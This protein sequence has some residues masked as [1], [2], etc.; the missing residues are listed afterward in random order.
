MLELKTLKLICHNP[1]YS[2][3]ELLRILD[4]PNS[5]MTNVINR[6]TSKGLLQRKLSNKDLR[7]FELELTEKGKEAVE[8]H[9]EAETGI[10][11]SMLNPLED[12]EKEEFIRLFEK[13][14]GKME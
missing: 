5:T 4:I 7:S 9:L 2:I 13:I 10:F 1:N 8:E 14:V 3:K 11:E 12:H 6:L